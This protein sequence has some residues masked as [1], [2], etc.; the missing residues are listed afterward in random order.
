MGNLAAIT[1]LPVI[2]WVISAVMAVLLAIPLHFLWS[3]LGPVYFAFI[4]A[5]YLNMGFWDTAG[6]L[7]LIGFI[8]I[9][10]LPSAFNHTPSK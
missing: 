6:M 1:A 5:L 4:P 7:V 9:I 8:K 10:A 3:W 2:G